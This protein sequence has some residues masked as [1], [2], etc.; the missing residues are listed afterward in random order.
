MKRNFARFGLI[1]LASGVLLT[2]CAPVLS[3]STAE[4]NRA[5]YPI[6]KQYD[7]KTLDSAAAELDGGSCPVLADMV[8]DYGQ[9]RD[10]TRVLLG[11]KVN[12]E[13]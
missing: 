3:D 4:I 7:D 2:A 11:E 1:V 5:N 8:V 10:E 13:R 12:V 6:V 9:M